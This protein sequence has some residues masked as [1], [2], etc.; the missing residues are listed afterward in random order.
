MIRIFDAGAL[1]LQRET[2]KVGAPVACG[3][4]YGVMLVESFFAYHEN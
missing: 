2:V 3:G 4:Q 1:Y